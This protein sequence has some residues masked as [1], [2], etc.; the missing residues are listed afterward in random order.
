MAHKVAPAL[1][2]GNP[3]ILRPASQTPVS[4]FKLAELVLEAGWPAGGIAVVPCKTKDANPL[5]EDNRIKL[6]TFT[7]SPAVGWELKSRAGQK[8]VTL[9][10]GGNAGNIVHNDA[11]LPYAAAASPGADSLTLDSRASPCSGSTFTPTATKLLSM[12]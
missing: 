10:L 1:A 6:L 8:F 9:E 12:N 5:V 4:S 3:I 11:D 2:A 7:G